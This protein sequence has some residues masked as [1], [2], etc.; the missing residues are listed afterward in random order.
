V[1]AFRKIFSRARRKAEIDEAVA[2]L[3]ES[4]ANSL[5]PRGA[6]KSVASGVRLRDRVLSLIEKVEAET[7]EQAVILAADA[8]LTTPKLHAEIQKH[9]DGAVLEPIVP[10]CFLMPEAPLY[11]NPVWP[12]KIVRFHGRANTDRL[13][14]DKASFLATFVICN[15]GA[16]IDVY[17][18]LEQHAPNLT[19]EAQLM[20]RVEEAA[21]WYRV[22]DELAYLFIRAQRPLFIDLFSDFLVESLALQGTPPDL[23]C[24]TMADR[25][26]EYGQYRE[27][28][29]SD[30]N[31]MAGTLLWN[32]AKHIGEPLG[33]DRNCLFATFLGNVFL[34]RVKEALV[35]E[36]LTGS[37]R[38]TQTR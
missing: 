32:A 12:S 13:L 17:N 28:A 34:T 30:A 9:S 18:M 10:M 38:E 3:K 6:I 14:F 36:L 20:V 11:F 33:M 7:G 29:T 25:S 24:Q 21:C 1:S 26:K 8:V 31:T 2:V 19:D 27:W 16:G 35:Y 37:A 4:L 23:I 15:L 5:K 22:I